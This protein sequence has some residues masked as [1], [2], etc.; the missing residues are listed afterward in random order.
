MDITQLNRDVDNAWGEGKEDGEL[1]DL[2]EAL[3]AYVESRDIDMNSPWGQVQLVMI[4]FSIF[5]IPEYKYD[6]FVNRLNFIQIKKL[7]G[8]YPASDRVH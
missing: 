8:Q 5:Q 6:E 4:L 3:K 1:K 2:K 7:E